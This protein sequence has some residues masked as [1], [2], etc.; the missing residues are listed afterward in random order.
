MDVLDNNAL[1]AVVVHELPAVVM[2]AGDEVLL[3]LELREGRDPMIL[4]EPSRDGNGKA[5]P[6]MEWE[7]A[8]GVLECIR[9]DEEDDYLRL[10]S[11]VVNGGLLV[12]YYQPDQPENGLHYSL[13]EE[14]SVVIS[15]E[16]DMQA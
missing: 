15:R 3:M 5:L 4:L 16:R 1:D 11:E 9:F 6:V 14:P 7:A 2:H 13:M 8:D 10:M 12:G